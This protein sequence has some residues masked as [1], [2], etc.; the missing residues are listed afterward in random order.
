MSGIVFSGHKWAA[1]E[2][3]GTLLFTSLCQLQHSGHFQHS[4]PLWM[5]VVIA[6][7][8]T[9]MAGSQPFRS[10]CNITQQSFNKSLTGQCCI[11]AATLIL[12]L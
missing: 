3:S 8:Y 1:S 6:K 5:A 12:M 7:F 9:H 11:I 2:V 10:H 4:Y